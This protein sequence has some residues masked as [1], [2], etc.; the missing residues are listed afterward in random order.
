MTSVPVKRT[1]VLVVDDSATVRL[2]ISRAMAA[3]PRL[4]VVGAVRTAEE[5][6][7]RIEQLAPD[8]MTL[9]LDLPGISG[10][11]LLQRLRPVR[12]VPTVVVSAHSARG[13]RLSVEAL[14]AGAVDVVEKPAPGVDVGAMLAELRTKVTIA[15]TARL[16]RF[17]QASAIAGGVSAPVALGTTPAKRG[18]AELIA[19]G[20]STGGPSAVQAVLETMPASAPPIIVAIHMPAG[21]TQSYA[22]RLNELCRLSVSE[23]RD[24]DELVP[25]CILVAPGGL[26]TRVRRKGQTYSVAV[27]GDERVNGHAPS[28]DVL[29][30]SVAQAAG[31]R[32]AAAILTGM[33]AD[34]ARGM[35]S[36]RQAGARTFAQDEASCVVFGMPKAAWDLGAVEAVVPLGD[37]AGRL[38]RY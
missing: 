19:I 34:G 31:A 37:I 38:L 27:T 9:D 24:G 23:A 25:G 35:L 28:V 6:L 21:F 2:M 36:M 17:K 16:G 10:I 30:E 13:A 20:A 33:G 11:E 32:S 4:E 7:E 14:A 3:D 22:Q 8:V 18:T 26:Q 5:A 1:R 12:P 29:F 15:A